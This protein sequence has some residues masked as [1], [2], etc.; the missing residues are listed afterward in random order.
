MGKRGGG[1]LF[2]YWLAPFITISKLSIAKDLNVAHV[3]V[4]ILRPMVFA[5]LLVGAMLPYWFSAMTMKSVGKAA[6]AMVAEVRRQ[7]TEHPKI[8]EGTELP[9]YARCVGISTAAS[10][11]QRLPMAMQMISRGANEKIV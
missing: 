3:G 5:G 4:D 1:P 6:Y 8:L 7:F 2:D 11:N 9:D 10:L